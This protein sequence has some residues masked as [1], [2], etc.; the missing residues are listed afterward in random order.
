MSSSENNIEKKIVLV[1][2]KIQEIGSSFQEIGK[3]WWISRSLPANAGDL[4]CMPKLQIT[5]LT[6]IILITFKILKEYNI[7]C[8]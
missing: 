1:S 2:L 8:N 5:L 3:I 6:P 4:T 7:I